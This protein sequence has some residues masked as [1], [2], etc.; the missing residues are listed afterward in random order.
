MEVATGNTP[1]LDD[2][3]VELDELLLALLALADHVEN[4]P[5]IRVRTRRARRARREKE[6]K[7]KTRTWRGRRRE[8]CFYWWR[9][10]EHLAF[11]KSRSSFTMF[12]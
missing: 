1:R 9:T 2:L 8:T 3:E 7:R 12:T 4:G 11:S 10:E 5:G 6:E